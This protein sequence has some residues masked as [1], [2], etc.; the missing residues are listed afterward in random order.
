LCHLL[1]LISKKIFPI[2]E[3]PL[4]GI[5]NCSNLYNYQDAAGAGSDLASTDTGSDEVGCSV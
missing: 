4:L 5:L 3:Y 2:T 1:F